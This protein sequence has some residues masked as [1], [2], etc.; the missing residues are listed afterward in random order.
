MSKK[1][2]P[3][4]DYVECTECGTC[5]N[6]CSHA[7]YNVDKAPTPVVINPDNCVQGCHGC[8]NQ[9][10]NGA[11]KYVGDNTNWTPP[12][13]KKENNDCGCNGGCGCDCG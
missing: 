6:F 1:W 11:I 2:Y 5:V 7:V 3:V 4:I 10:P 8:G 9:C 13:A 12:K